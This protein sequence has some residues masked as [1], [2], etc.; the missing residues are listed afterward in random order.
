MDKFCD[1]NFGADITKIFE[2]HVRQSVPQY[3]TIQE[4]VSQMSDFFIDEK[5]PVIDIGCSTGETISKIN[6]RHKDKNI[7]YIGIDESTDMIE[8]AKKKLLYMSNI[9]LINSSIQN[10]EFKTKSNLI[11]AILVLQ[12]CPEKDRTDILNRI[13]ENLNKGGAFILVEKTY[14]QNIKSQDIFT[15]IYH[16]FKESKGLTSEEIRSKDKSLRSQLNPMEIDEYLKILKDCGFKTDIFFKHLNFT[17]IIC[18][19]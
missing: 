6:L 18:I 17:G 19:K 14:P 7:N 5:Y 2:Q 3:E 12:F 4:L 13:Y 16:D 9:T 8:Q 15:Q 10:Y 11:L 1:W